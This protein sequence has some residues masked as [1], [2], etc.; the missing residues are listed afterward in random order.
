MSNKRGADASALP[1][2]KKQKQE[3]NQFL[4]PGD[5]Q[6]QSII[7]KKLTNKLVKPLYKSGH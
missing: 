4:Q 7:D 2:P 3:K 6:A 5:L 1:Q